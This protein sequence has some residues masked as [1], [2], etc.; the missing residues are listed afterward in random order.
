M[1]TA[2]ITV[3]GVKMDVRFSRTNEDKE[4]GTPESIDIESVAVGGKDITEIVA[5]TVLHKIEEQIFEVHKT[6]RRRSDVR[7]MD[8]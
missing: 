7:D 1:N 2:E 5:L 4:T 8:L 3:Y 6:A